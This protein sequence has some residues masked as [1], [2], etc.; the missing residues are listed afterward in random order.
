MSDANIHAAIAQH[1]ATCAYTSRQRIA[2][3][4]EATDASA[5][6]LQSLRTHPTPDGAEMLAI[7]FAGMQR[8]AYQISLALSREAIQ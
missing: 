5:A 8:A 3:L 1:T 7:Q 6:A 4:I 2:D